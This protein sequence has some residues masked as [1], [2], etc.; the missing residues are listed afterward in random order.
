MP[1]LA[2]ALEFIEVAVRVASREE[3]K[4]IPVP[5]A[6]GEVPRRDRR[7][8][9]Q[10]GTGIGASW[11]SSC[12]HIDCRRIWHPQIGAYAPYHHLYAIGMCFS[13]SNNL[14]ERVSAPSKSY[15]AANKVAM[16]QEIVKV[17]GISLNMA[18]EAAANEVQP[19]NRVF[20]PQN[21]VKSKGCLAGINGALRNYF[22]MLPMMPGGAEIKKRL[23]EA[24]TL[25]PG[26]FEY[27]WSAD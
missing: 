5:R 17:A 6:T 21:W 16:V 2:L 13:I 10:G 11:R 8:V 18:L 9:G 22:A 27:R 4:A 14:A 15:A 20:S 7:V 26:D 25:S 12:P 24:T 3:L 1:S 19:A 23:T